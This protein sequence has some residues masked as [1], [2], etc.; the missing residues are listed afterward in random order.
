MRQR[1]VDLEHNREVLGYE[2]KD[3]GAEW[4]APPE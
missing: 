4:D 2:P 3:N 1:W